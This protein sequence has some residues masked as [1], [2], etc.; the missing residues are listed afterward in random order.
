MRQPNQTTTSLHLD[1]KK[2][3]QCR[4]GRNMNQYAGLFD[5]HSKRRSGS[6]HSSTTPATSN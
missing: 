5:R 4:A 2:D 1:Q 3:R 6:A